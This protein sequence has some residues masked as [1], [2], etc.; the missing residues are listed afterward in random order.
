MVSNEKFQLMV[1]CVAYNH[2]HKALCGLIES[3]IEIKKVGKNTY[4]VTANQREF[5]IAKLAREAQKARMNAA[6]AEDALKW[7]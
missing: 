5:G 6:L 4:Q 1:D 7:V 2:A 3:S